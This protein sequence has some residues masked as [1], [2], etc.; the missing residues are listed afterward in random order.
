MGI[1]NILAP[2]RWR[3]VQDRV[4]SCAA[5]KFGGIDGGVQRSVE[6][7]FRSRLSSA[8]IDGELST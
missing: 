1:T 6:A 7:G 3:L 5:P 8:G 2:Q 4:D